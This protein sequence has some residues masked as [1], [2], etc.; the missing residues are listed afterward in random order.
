M[1]ESIKNIGETGLKESPNK[2]LKFKIKDGSVTT[3][4]IA[5]KAVTPEKLS[6]DV[7]E[8]I[9][10]PVKDDLQRQIDSL[11]IGGVALKQEFGNEEHYGVS[12]KVI[13]DAFN[14]VWDAI[15]DITGESL[16]GMKVTATPDYYVGEEG[17][18]I[19]LTVDTLEA[20]SFFDYLNIY[21]NDEL[22]VSLKNIE[23]YEQD[24][25]IEDTAVVKCT[26]SIL[27]QEATKSVTI[28]HYSS[29]WIG[30]GSTYSG[31]MVNG[32]L[33]PVTKHLKGSYPITMEDG[34]HL[35]IIMYSSM[36]DKFIR[37]D[38]NGF[39]IPF[40]ETVVTVEG[41]EYAVFESVNRYEAGTYNIDINS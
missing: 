24:F 6:D 26:G 22:I 18:T 11:V 35:Y 27:G 14:K 4:K 41:T 37:A 39:E 34:N 5:D 15:E 10:G 21:I 20:K 33:K 40:T 9:V 8:Y 32:N 29:Y 2:P 12:Q 17:C 23:S 19:H 7:P 25:F 31:A 13:T 30:G 38:M 3:S 16:Y 1:V 36:R 28:H